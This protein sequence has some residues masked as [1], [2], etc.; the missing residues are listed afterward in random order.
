MT[1]TIKSPMQGIVN[2]IYVKV[3]DKVSQGDVLCFVEAMKMLTPI[4]SPVDGSISE[5]DIVEKQ[6]VARGARL[7]VIEY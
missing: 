2:S 7:M 5:I 6:P 1:K 3:G 4:E